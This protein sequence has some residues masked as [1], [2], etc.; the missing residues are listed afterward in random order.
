MMNETN[1]S[2][3]NGNINLPLNL[4]PVPFLTIIIASKL[5]SLQH[6]SR[7]I[8]IEMTSHNN[9]FSLSPHSI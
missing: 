5:S 1:Y 7:E 3:G 8:I 9:N 6:F 4:L 2:M